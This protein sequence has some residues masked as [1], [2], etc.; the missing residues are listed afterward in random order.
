MKV[1][2]PRNTTIPTK[3]VVRN[4]TAF[5][6]QVWVSFPV[7]EGERPIAKDNNY[8]GKFCL[9]DI[10]PAPRC[11]PTFDVCFS[12]DV[13]GILT[14]SAELVGTHNKKQITIANHSGRLSKEKIDQMVE[15]AK[16]YKA[17]DE[18]R[19][20][21]AKAKN[22]LETYVYEMKGTLRGI[23]KRVNM[24]DKRKVN[25]VI[26][27]ITQWLEW[28]NLLAESCK[29]EE[30]MKELESICEPIIANMKK[31]EKTYVEEIEIVELD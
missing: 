25:D 27:H 12:I 30:K 31:Q 16:K 24:K 17:E 28:N 8:L 20:K 19:K 1:V 10:P 4:T 14:V 9:Y 11:V 22:T 29:F 5:D 7:Y 6:N 21:A 26:E 15:T 13:D 23:V 2:I 3:M 18:E